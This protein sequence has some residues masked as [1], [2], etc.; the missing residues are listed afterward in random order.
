MAN[1]YNIKIL[2]INIPCDESSGYSPSLKSHFSHV[3]KKMLAHMNSKC[4]LN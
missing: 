4:S 3:K 2:D 1:N